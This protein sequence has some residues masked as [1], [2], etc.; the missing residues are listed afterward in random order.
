MTTADRST[1]ALA[2]PG[3]RTFEEIA[4]DDVDVAP[5]RNPRT[6]MDQERLADLASSIRQHGVLQPVLVEHDDDGYTV[7]AGHRRL[8]AARLAGLATVPA[9][10]Q[11]V[12]GDAFVEA[13]VENLL[14]EDLTPLEEAQA[15]HRLQEDGGLSQRDLAERVTK[16]VGWVNERLRLLKLPEGVRS[17]L[18]DGTVP[19]SSAPT[20]AK[21]AE[22]SPAAAELVVEEVR[23][24]DL[25][26]SELA[27]NV[28]EVLDELA[29]GPA[30]E[31]AGLT[32]VMPQGLAF[33]ELALPDE[34]RADLKPR[35]ESVAKSWG[36]YLSPSFRFDDDDIAAARA[37]GCLLELENG[38]ARQ[39][40]PWERETG[41][42]FTDP[43]F[44][45]E[46]VHVHL[47][48]MEQ[49][50]KDRAGRVAAARPP[51]AES[52]KDEQEERRRERE[53]IAEE[54]VEAREA[55][56][57]LGRRMREAFAAPAIDVESA[58]L[59]ALLAVGEH[60]T[61]IAGRGLRYVDERWHETEEN[62]NGTKVT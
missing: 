12:N 6:S 42:Y 7:V 16:S 39:R 59:L 62:R 35:Y 45:V 23:R 15:L 48:R 28:V 49:E 58:R 3:Q 13:L 51:A 17:A 29:I 25:E 11:S 5:G 57:E 40:R 46:R 41:V 26:R 8:A 30:G 56:L 32:P 37:A 60:A 9:F 1:A 53:R 55:N 14:R 44:V 38:D 21:V 31:A 27:E 10:V 2:E 4:I 61:S 50:A 47:E 52:T 34:I 22:A 24:G 18:G 36:T 43:I 20:L 19:L 33:S 54:R